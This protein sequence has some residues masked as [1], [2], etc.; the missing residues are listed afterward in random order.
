MCGI[1]RWYPRKSVR[2]V[3]Q[4][5]IVQSNDSVQTLPYFLTTKLREFVVIAASEPKK[6][7]SMVERQILG[8]RK[9]SGH[10][11]LEQYYECPTIHARS[12]KRAPIAVPVHPKNRRSVVSL[13][14]S[15]RDF[16][17]SL[18]STAA[19][20]ATNLSSAIHPHE[21]IR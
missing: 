15:T 8:G 16:F 6:A 13:F 4:Q 18:N 2:N 5:I 12:G 20:F 1:T 21:S 11:I 3:E 9:L 17:A 7:K 10:S 19:Q 14:H